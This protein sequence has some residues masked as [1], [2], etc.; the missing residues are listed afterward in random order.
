MQGSSFAFIQ[1]II[2]GAKMAGMA[3]IQGALMVGGLI[4]AFLG[5]TGLIG[6]IRKL[7]TPLIIGVTIFLIGASLFS[8]PA[9]LILSYP[10]LD[11][12]LLVALVT[13]A[14]ALFLGLRKDILS[15][16]SVLV[17]IVVGFLLSLLLGMVDISPLF[18][19]PPISLPSLFPWGAPVFHEVV[20]L[21]ILVAFLVSIV[22]SI[23]DY[24][25][26]GEL[27]GK[28]VTEREINRGI[29]SEGLGSFI[30]G[31]VGGVGTTSYSENIGLISFTGVG[32][33]YVVMVAG[34]ILV[35][36]SLLPPVS[37]FI[38]L[39]PSPVVG[40]IT[41]LLF[42]MISALGIKIL[43]E[44]VPLTKRNSVIIAVSLTLGL[45][46]PLVI[47]GTE[48]PETLKAVLSSGMAVGMFTSLL[49]EHLLPK[50]D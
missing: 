19:V 39:L 5:Y 43:K 38:S 45:G 2:T 28:K 14:T 32:S 36:L 33:R 12:S 26:V 22:E 29:G 42:G 27:V 11:K 13:L 50:E 24:Y 47:G 8:V 34:V 44:N 30:S 49:L 37:T 18:S 48:L 7:L 4:E 15:T 16:V 6:K 46:T 21:L 40:G 20:I 1:P 31:I 41:L 23:G 3:A 35:I 17:A 9:S 10:E 25:S